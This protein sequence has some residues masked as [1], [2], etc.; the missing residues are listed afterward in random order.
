M[1]LPPNIDRRLLRAA[2]RRRRR[3]ATLLPPAVGLAIFIVCLGIYARLAQTT[4]GEQVVDTLLELGAIVEF[5]AICFGIAIP[6]LLAGI[7][8]VG[9][10]RIFIGNEVR[11]CRLAP[12][13][14][15]CES[16][17]L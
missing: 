7:V 10:E 12:C 17:L 8:Y 15:W 13:C 3:N 2:V 14:V 11:R 9:L 5:L 16:F 6:I 4:L 1:K